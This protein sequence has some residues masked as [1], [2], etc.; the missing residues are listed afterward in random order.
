MSAQSNTNW[1]YYFICRIIIIII[2]I[3]LWCALSRKRQLERFWQ[4]GFGG[5]IFCSA[6]FSQLSACFCL[7]A[8]DCV[9]LSCPL[10]TECFTDL[11]SYKGCMQKMQKKYEYMDDFRNCSPLLYRR[12]VIFFE[13]QFLHVPF[14]TV[15]L[16]FYY[17]TLS[18]KFLHSFARPSH[19]C[20]GWFHALYFPHAPRRKV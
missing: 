15:I 1:K 5:H 9:L 20:I 2:T 16:I 19:E 14:W 8:F 10:M 11:T 6:Q 12:F 3:K 13:A 18:F 17:G 4:R 7:R